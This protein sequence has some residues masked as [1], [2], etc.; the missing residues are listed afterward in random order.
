MG[1]EATEPRRGKKGSS[2]SKDHWGSLRGMS[3]LRA[4]SGSRT[5]RISRSRLLTTWA[6]LHSARL[7][8]SW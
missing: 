7:R 8:R 1:L 6:V 3:V 2:Y 4:H 5:R